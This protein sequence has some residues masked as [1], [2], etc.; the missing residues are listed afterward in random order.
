MTAARQYWFRPKRFGY[1]AEPSN[2]KGWLA[3][4]AYILFALAITLQWIIL[5][6]TDGQ[7]VASQNIT[8]W[9]V[10]LIAATA[11]FVWLAWIKT[12]GAWR[13]RSGKNE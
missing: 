13:W 3:T 5:P 10:V 7:S 4:G 11:A 6:S 9:V 8:L 12:D 1:G 2:W